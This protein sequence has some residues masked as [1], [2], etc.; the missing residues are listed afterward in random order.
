MA[1]LDK[2]IKRIEFECRLAEDALP[3][4]GFGRGFEEEVETYAKTLQVLKDAQERE[5]SCWYCSDIE[6]HDI[7]YVIVYEYRL[8]KR[9]SAPY[10]VPNNFCTNCGRKLK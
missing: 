3:H 10:K 1:K 7:D 4:Y 6:Q 5:T 8:D 9:V 2:A